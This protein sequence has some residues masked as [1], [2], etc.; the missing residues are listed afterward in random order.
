MPDSEVTASDQKQRILENLRTGDF[1]ELSSLANLLTY[2]GRYQIGHGTVIEHLYRLY[3]IMKEQ[4]ILIFE[5]M[6]ERGFVAKVGEDVY[7]LGP[8][9]IN[10]QPQ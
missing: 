9:I 6:L 5:S 2:N 1:N 3:G 4:G 7:S 10:K 8:T